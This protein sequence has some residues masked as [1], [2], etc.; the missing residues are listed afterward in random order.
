MFRL[1]TPVIFIACTGENIIEKQNNSA[2]LVLIG[3]HSDGAEVLEGYAESFRATVSDDND[4][5]NELVTA[6]YVG[7]EIVCDW[8]EVSPAGESTCAIVFTPDD[9]NVIIEVRDPDGAGGRDEVSIS[10]L[11]TEA[12]VIEILS[13]GE[14]ASFYSDQLVRFEALVSDDEDNAEALLIIWSSSIDGELLLD[15]APDSTGAILDYGYL[16]EGQHAIEFYVEDT[17]GKVSREQIIVQVGGENTN[18]LCEI[19]LPEDLSTVVVG[20]SILFRASISDEN[21]DA[22]DLSTMWVSDKDGDL[23]TGTISSNGDLSFTYSALTAND[24]VVSLMVE[25]E[26]GAQCQDTIVLYV[27][28]PPDVEIIAPLNNEVASVGDSVV[29]QGSIADTE[30]Q[31]SELSVVWSS[32]LDGELSTGTANSQGISQFASSDLTAGMHS[33]LVTATDSSGLTSD[34]LIL[35]RVNTPPTAPNVTLSP[36]PISS[37]QT[38][39]VVATGS[40]DADGDNISYSYQWFENGILVSATGTSIPATDLDVGEVW[41]VQV[42]PNDGYVD[43]N[44]TETSITISNS[45]P[46][47]ASVL[48]SSSDGGSSYNDS[49]LTCIAS[50]TDADETV[51]PTYSWNVNGSIIVGA[52]V[53]LSNY[54]TMPGDSVSCTASV[55]DSN[56]GADSSSAAENMDNRSPS[57]N[58]VTIT[59]TVALSDSLLTCTSGSSDADGE[60]I[61]T[62]YEW[63]IGSSFVGGNAELQLDNSLVIPGT[64]VDCI[65]SIE[66]ESGATDQ[67]SVPTT[68]Q[69]SAPVLGAIFLTPAE[70]SL[71]DSISCTSS[72]TDIDGDTP[73]LSFSFTNQ[74]SG[75]AYSA[76]T[77]TSSS[78]TLDLSSTTAVSDDVISCSV[79]AADADGGSATDSTSVMIINTSPIFDQ[80]AEISPNTGVYNGTDL[81]CSAVASDPDDGVASLSYIWLVNSI[82]VA[83]GSTWTVTSGDAPVGSSVTCTAIAIDFEGNTTTSNSSAVS[84]ENSVPEI[85]SVYLSTLSPDT[86]TALTATVIGASDNDGDSITYSYEWH[87]L[88]ASSA[89]VDII[90]STGS[91]SSFSTLNG[92]FAFDRNDEIYVLVTPND[93]LDDGLTVESDHAI[94]LNTAPTEPSIILTSAVNPPME[95]VDD[96][97]CSVTGPSMDLDGNAI[98]YL[99]E[100]LDNVNF[101]QQ[102]TSN[103]LST[104]DIYLGSGTTSGTWTCLVSAFDGTDYSTAASSQITIDADWAGALSF[105]NCG[106]A[107][108]TGPSQSQC[109]GEYSGTDLAGLV[110]VSSGYQTWTVPSSG[111]Y[112]IEVA[113]AQGGGSAGGNGAVMVGDVILIAGEELIIVVGHL[114][115]TGGTG[116][117][118]GGGG[119]GSFVVKNAMPLLIAGGGGGSH[120]N[121]STSAISGQSGVSGLSNASTGSGYTS[122]SGG[123]WASDGANG[124]YGATGGKGWAN[125]LIGGIYATSG[126][127]HWSNGNGG[128]GGG[129]GG[130]WPGGSGG[131]YNGGVSPGSGGSSTPGGSGAGSYNSGINQVNTTGGNAGNGYVIIDKL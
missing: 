38:L 99:Y 119:G 22:T 86:N 56:G 130:A 19:L 112:N 91:G 64:I 98:T 126:N 70:P 53:D 69:N 14:G 74:T 27:G 43:G 45:E 11:P 18:P 2:P 84:V 23:G 117:G 82:Q 67:A 59:P 57:V 116:G 105:T 124:D 129:G 52:S 13:P 104:S 33:I 100:W 42:T 76:T 7:E 54:S 118:G 31:P 81:E 44:Y 60:A 110:T 122:G 72:A 39:N 51:V 121:N 106:Q 28:N 89:G 113:G 90:V 25:D 5:F 77:V 61:T 41:T 49:V 92:A 95:G 15:T 8:T 96:L 40:T 103:S 17:S 24:H 35:F 78:A 101:T 65:V 107:G 16:S 62:T 63:Q 114:A 10:V 125:G 97:T 46:V 26:V 34:D 115:D 127:A 1:V 30:D 4:T 29:F 32:S 20:D 85:A 73:S 37:T 109:D 71:S 80:A 102:I 75:A 87:I 131:G 6:W 36:D 79:T 68:I 55:S 47:I 21:I 50:A 93:G 120:S 9:T 48:I 3:S 94:A 58:S 123:S 88:D 12:P 83:T 108:S 111:T 66:D 128:F